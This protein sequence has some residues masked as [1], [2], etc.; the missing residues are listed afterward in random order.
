MGQEREEYCR[1]RSLEPCKGSR[2]CLLLGPIGGAYMVC[3]KDFDR[4]Q[5]ERRRRIEERKQ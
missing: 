2:G 4:Q 3:A 5:E 1:R